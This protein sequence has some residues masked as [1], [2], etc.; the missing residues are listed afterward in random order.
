MTNRNRFRVQDVIADRELADSIQNSI[1]TAI[2]CR[3][4][5][6]P[7]KRSVSHVFTRS[8]NASIRDI[9]NHP[10]GVLLRRL[11]Q[12]GPHSPIG[13]EKFWDKGKE[14]LSD[15]ECVQCVNFIFFHLVNRFKGELAELL[16][17]KP[18]IQLLS[19]LREE[20]KLSTDIQLFWGETIEEPRRIHN[21]AETASIRYKGYAKGADGLMLV[22]P[23]GQLTPSIQ[24]AIC[25]VLEIKSMPVSVTRISRQISK[26]IKRLE[27]GVRLNGVPMDTQKL[28]EK[29]IYRVIVIPSQWKLSRKWKWID[30]NDT[31]EMD[32][33]ER[34]IPPRPTRIEEISP[35]FWKIT[36]S[37]S[38][39][40]LEEVAYEMTFRY[41]AEIGMHI[42]KKHG[43]MSQWEMAHPDQ[44]GFNAIKEALYYLM[45]REITIFQ[46]HRTKKLYNIYSYG[47]PVGVD[48][49]H[50]LRPEDLDTMQMV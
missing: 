42:F 13:T 14:R 32:Y 11:L 26:H 1:S 25:G 50:M 23:T 12:F 38:R 44:A 45:L 43:K 10:R 7:T 48:A 39:E 2:S 17:L 35:R 30:N 18:C 34:I 49:K 20:G 41:M 4:V 27:G 6:L 9:D 15:P 36:L 5:H 47:Y 37:W 16:A 3:F 29:S 24:P 8:L 40:A 28:S 19:E 21:S 33:Y 46:S 31:R 22:L